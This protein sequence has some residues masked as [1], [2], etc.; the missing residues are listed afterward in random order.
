MKDQAVTGALWS[1]ADKLG[2]QALSFLSFLLMARMLAPEDFGVVSLA[3]VIVAV[4]A[5]LLN[6]GF[7]IALIQRQDVSDDH[8][9]A[10]FW[11]NLLLAVCLVALLQAS[12][13]TIGQLTGKPMVG[14]LISWLCFTCIGTALN[15]IAAS[16]HIRQLKFSRFPQSSFVSIVSGATIAIA[17]ATA[18]FGVWSLVAF[19]LITAFTPSAVLWWGVNWRPRLSVSWQALHDLLHFG[20]TTTLG[21]LFRFT[22]ERVDIIVIGYFLDDTSL[23]YYYLMARLIAMLEM[24]ILDPLDGI[25]I[26]L[27]SRLQNDSENLKAYYLEMLWAS[28]ALWLPAVFGLGAIASNVLPLTFG[29]HWTGAIPMLIGASLVG[30]TGSFVRVTSFLLLAMGLPKVYANINLM[31]VI[32]AAAVMTCA[33]QFG[34]TALGLGFALVSLLMLPVHLLVVRRVASMQ[35]LTILRMYLPIALAGSVMASAGLRRR[36]V[37]FGLWYAAYPDFGRTHCL[38]GSAVPYRTGT[39]ASLFRNAEGL[40]QSFCIWH[41]GFRATRRSSPQPAPTPVS[42]A[43]YGPSEGALRAEDGGTEW[44]PW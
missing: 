5:L 1:F 40:L 44:D 42:P 10:A 34:T 30:L 33:S 28:T 22:A 36:D 41:P 9:N 19:Q 25:M 13:G 29:E 26:V 6:E 24:A 2:A 14:T 32:V 39:S 38:F 43:L 17:M 31:R 37:G 27:F 4:P 21:N 23:G 16:L 18:G 12:A 15:S 3:G 8:I 20:L 35:I 7:G 11:A